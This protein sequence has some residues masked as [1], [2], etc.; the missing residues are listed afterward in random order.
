MGS[1]GGDVEE[2]GVV[3]FDGFV[4]EVEGFFCEDV[5]RVE[6]FVVFGGVLVLLEGGVEIVVGVWV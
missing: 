6:F 5:D 2:E 1:D 3:G 4:D